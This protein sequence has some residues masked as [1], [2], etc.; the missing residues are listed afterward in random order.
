MLHAKI[1]MG[2]C[3]Q[4]YSKNKSEYTIVGAILK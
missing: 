4:V 1:L 3:L 2:V